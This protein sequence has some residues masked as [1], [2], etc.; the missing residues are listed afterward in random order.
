MAAEAQNL[1][2]EMAH[3]YLTGTI[4]PQKHARS[5]PARGGQYGIRHTIYA[6][7]QEFTR[8]RRAIRDTTGVYPLA[9]GNTRQNM[10][11]KPNFQN[12]KMTVT[13]YSTKDYENKSLLGRRKNKANSNPIKPNFKVFA[14]DV[15]R[16]K[17][18]P[19]T[20]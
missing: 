7:R 4:R 9:A 10:Q 11:N 15:I 13:L 16:R 2:R 14:V 3:A 6:I 8:S 12:D 18:Y 5:L 17:L 20:G 19:V 1:P